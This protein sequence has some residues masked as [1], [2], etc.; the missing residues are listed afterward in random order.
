MEITNFLEK[1]NLETLWDVISDEDIFKFLS[2]DIQNNVSKIFLNN[3]KGFYDTEKN[4]NDNL[5]VM[6]KKY[7]LLILNYI[8][9][10][11]PNKMPNKIKI[12]D[13][14]IKE[15]I[16]YEEIQNDRKNIIDQKFNLLQ[17]EFTNAMTL[18]VPP[19]P[20]FA[21][22]NDDVPIN[23]MDKIIKEMTSKRNYD[24]EQI[25]YNYQSNI[26]SA[27]NWLKSQDTSIKA[28][29]FIQKNDIQDTQNNNDK[30]QFL[31]QNSTKK[32]VTW[33]ENNEINEVLYSYDGNEN[34]NDENTNDED[35][36]R[37][38]KKIESKNN[39]NTN[40]I[41]K[42]EKNLLENKIEKLEGEI[43][44]VNLKIDQIITLLKQNR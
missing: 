29:K 2:K 12:H 9:V 11:Y 14:P 8:K 4:K 23:E 26:N 17:E 7:I 19:V 6:N 1:K 38:L 24:I 28:E 37:K 41:N 20:D 15:S 39:E 33:G 21:D 44:L 3:I 27:N 35:I 40:F 18:K 32:N 30:L 34:T 13:Q 43:K 16:T 22:K 31:N 5:I 10:H 36:F 25:N 42:E